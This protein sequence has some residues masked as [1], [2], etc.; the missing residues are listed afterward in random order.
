MTNSQAHVTPWFVDT[1]THLISGVYF[2][3]R[4]TR[5]YMPRERWIGHLMAWA[6]I[7]L[8]IGGNPSRFLHEDDE[9]ILRMEQNNNGQYRRG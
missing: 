3:T 2:S 1:L 5:N 9:Q 4:Q 7:L 6:S 8:A